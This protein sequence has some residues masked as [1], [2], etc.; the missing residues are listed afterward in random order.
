MYRHMLR[1]GADGDGEEVLQDSTPSMLARSSSADGSIVHSASSA[2]C[3][4]K[5]KSMYI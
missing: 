2:A 5:Q 4:G 1:E 3:R